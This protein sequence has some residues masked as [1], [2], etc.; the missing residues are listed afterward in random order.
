MQI[1]LKLSI[2][3]TIPVSV[4]QNVA[5]VTII[6]VAI[7][8]KVVKRQLRTLENIKNDVNPTKHYTY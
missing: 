8:S 5:L 7:L 1:L 4:R 2:K 6:G 3:N